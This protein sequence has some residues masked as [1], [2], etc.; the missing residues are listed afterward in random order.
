MEFNKIDF[1][2]GINLHIEG[3][4]GRYNTLPI[5][6][7]IEIG[8]SLQDLLKRTSIETSNPTQSTDFE[9]FIKVKTDKD[10]FIPDNHTSMSYAP[11][12]IDFNNKKYIL[13]FPL[14]CLFE[15]EDDY[16]VIQSE[17]LDIIGTGNTKEAAELSFKQEFNYIYTLYNG[18]E[19]EKL[20][21]RLLK[22]KILLNNI[23]KKVV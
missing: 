9:L 13:N 15:K 23:V 8:K 18:T 21:K 22:I 1:D 10:S 12:E 14:R 5:D 4:L 6:V 2:K 11:S 16:F 3:E 17:M 7:L 19:D 20:S